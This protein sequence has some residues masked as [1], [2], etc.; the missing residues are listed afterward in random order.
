M[1]II[2]S[3]WAW[4]ASAWYSQWTHVTLSIVSDIEEETTVTGTIT[5]HVADTTYQVTCIEGVISNIDNINGT[6]DYTTP[7]VTEDT[8]DTISII[9]TFDGNEPSNQLDR[10]ITITNRI[11]ITPILYRLRNRWRDYRS[12]NYN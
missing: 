1:H 11:S 3:Y 2:L 6:F 12:R 7:E 9:A 5:N 10:N 8:P 4:L